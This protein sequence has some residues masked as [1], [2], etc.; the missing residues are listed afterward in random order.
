MKN[1]CLSTLS[2]IRIRI[3]ILILTLSPALLVDLRAAEMTD[4]SRTSDQAARFAAF[5]KAEAVLLDE[6]PIL[7]V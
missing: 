1:Y 7:P 2:Q 5:Q 3:P 4:A 6:A